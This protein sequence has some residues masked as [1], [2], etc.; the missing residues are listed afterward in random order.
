MGVR[1]IG[2]KVLRSED[3][4]LVTGHGNYVDDI[5]LENMAYVTFVRSE[6]AHAKIIDID[7]TVALEITGVFGIFRMS[8][9]EEPYARRRLTEI[10]PS[11]LIKQLILPL[12]LARDEVCHVGDPIV[13]VVAES[14]AIAEDA[15]ARVIVNYEPLAAVVD[16]EQALAADAP[17]AHLS[18]PDNLVAELKNQFGDIVDAFEN[19]EHVFSCGFRQHRGG[20]HS[21]ECRGVV[22]EYNPYGTGYTI[23]SSTQAPFLVR[24]GIARF[25]D[26]DESRVRVIAPDV[27][28]G[29]GPKA[30]IYGEEILLPM[31]A[32][33]LGRPVKWTEDRQEHFTATNQQGDMVWDLEVAADSD[34]KMRGVRG[35]AIVDNGAYVPYGLLLPFTAIMPLPGP[36]ALPALDIHMDVVFTNTTC[37]SPVRGAG[38]PNAAY[39]M[40]RM[41]ETVSCNLNLDPVEVRRKNFVKADQFPYQPGH[42]APNGKPITYD[43]GNF[44][45]CMDK[46]VELADYEQF[47]TRQQAAAAE[48]RYIGIGVSSCIEDTGL[49]PFEGVSVEI[50]PGGKV[51][52][53]AGAASQGQGHATAFSQIVA[54]RLGV[55]IED[56]IYRSADTGQT[57]L[58]VATVGSR[59]ASTAGPAAYAA[60][61]EVR[62]KAISLAAQ[63]LELDADTLDIE[64]GVV[65]PSND[66]S[67]N[68]G[69]SLGE[70]AFKLAPMTN[71][72]MPEGF[73]PGL[74]ATSYEGSKGHPH[75]SG[76]NIAEVEVDI[77]TGDVKVLKY[78]VAH[79]CG[80]MI[81]PLLVDGQIIGGV[82]HGIGNALFERMVYDQ[83]GQPLSTNYG[84]YLLPIATEM[85]PINIVH[86]ETPSPLN[87]LGIKGAGEGGTIPAANAIIAAIENALSSFG[88]RIDSHPVDPQTI[89]RLVDKA[90]AKTG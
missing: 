33:K 1:Y 80:T 86:Q 34:G 43:S 22:A 88:I 70:L 31:L 76:S 35:K 75:A 81:N 37:N 62:D 29:F 27:G 56:V 59:V 11:P 8:D 25:L 82:V 48:G 53:L 85:P 39:A 66:P 26:E 23:W 18:S 42:K 73:T 83:E 84:E 41:I 51:L 15:A 45:G 72:L 32:R 10:Y 7:M 50:Q 9:F 54:D 21:M 4:R 74:K 24:R 60:A 19:A 3:P 89:C 6:H 5:Q 68:V 28:G 49:G 63:L 71:Q 46:V 2:A 20:C 64:D 87:S 61:T 13:A 17:L 79:D 58:G 30:G 14:R 16:C 69:I 57:P 55:A 40:E 38:R 77:E 52:V 78:S 90:R 12:L 44:H 67:A 36:Y 65:R 47:K